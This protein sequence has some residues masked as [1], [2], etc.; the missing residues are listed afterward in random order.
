[1]KMSTNK[2]KRY[3]VEYVH[4]DGNRYLIT[5]TD[6][7]ELAQAAADSFYTVRK[8]AKRLKLPVLITDRENEEWGNLN[9][10]L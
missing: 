10:E 5:E 2:G 6:F 7:P 4:L 3:V 9:G 1:M 8:D